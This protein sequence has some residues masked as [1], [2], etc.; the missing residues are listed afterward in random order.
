MISIVR[1]QVFGRDER[2]DQRLEIRLPV[3]WRARET[4]HLREVASD[5]LLELAAGL[6]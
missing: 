2:R 4:W 5:S 1:I 6:V 3:Q